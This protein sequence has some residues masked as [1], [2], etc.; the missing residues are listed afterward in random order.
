MMKGMTFGNYWGN[1]YQHFPLLSKLYIDKIRD[2]V[3]YEARERYFKLL[4]KMISSRVALEKD[5]K[6]DFTTSLPS[7]SKAQIEE[8]TSS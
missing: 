7:T 2:K 8:A 3:F 6:S 4:E 1:V 5:A